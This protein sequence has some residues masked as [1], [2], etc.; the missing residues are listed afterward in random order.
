[1]LAALL[2]EGSQLDA[3]RRMIA[4]RTG[5]NPF[6]I[7]EM[8][9][10][11]FEQGILA[12]NG[13]VKLVRPL[14]EAYLPVTVQGVLAARIDRLPAPDKE[15]LQTLAVIG[16]EFP[17]AL[18]KRVSQLRDDGLERGLASLRVAEFIY[19]R[20]RLSDIEYSFKHALTY[21]VAYNSLLIERRKLLHERAGQ[22]LES[23]FAEH[24]DDHLGELARHYSRSNNTIKA[25][26][27]LGR[28]GQQ[29]LQRSASTEAITRINAAIELLH[30]L[31]DT[32]QRA[33]QELALHL[34]VGP[35]LIATRGTRPQKF[36]KHT[37]GRWNYADATETIL[38]CSKSSLACGL[39]TW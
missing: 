26:E 22:A 12:R 9:R 18:V 5:G 36:R 10:A 34:L 27:Y 14:G 7:E 30:K 37:S 35:A 15:L 17:L 39:F 4:E 29:A 16:H 1:M 23:M 13:V 2:R 24:L 31:A 28:A 20:P 38:S 21:E 19:E 6:F 3:L 25:I 8:V 11:L 32:A 33:Q